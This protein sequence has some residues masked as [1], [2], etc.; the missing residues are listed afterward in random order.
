MLKHSLNRRDFLRLAGLTAASTAAAACAAP[1]TPAPAA[2]AA[3]EGAAQEAEPTAAP[4]AAAATEIRVTHWWGDA[5]NEPIAAFQAANPGVTVKNEAAPWDGYHEKLPTMVAAGNSPDVAFM[6]AGMFM[7][8]LPQGVAKDVTE[9]LKSDPDVKADKWAIDPAIDTGYDNKAF[10]I[11]QWHPDS[12]NIVVNKDLFDAA[13]IKVPELGSDLFMKWTW[14]DFLEAAQALTKKTADGKYEQWGIGGVGRGV[15]SPHRDMVWSNAAEFYDDPTHWAPTKALFTEPAFVEAWQWIVDLDL[16]HGVATKPE[17]ESAMGSEGP[18][19][20]GK[21][22][23]TWMWNLYGTMSKAPFAWTVIAPPFQKLRPNK[24]GGNSW[25]MS[26]VTKNEQAAWS[27]MKW[28]A[29]TAEGSTAFAKVGTLPAY[30]PAALLPTA[31]SEGQRTLWQLIIERQKAAVADKIARP[32]SL[33]RHGNEIT[34]I[35]NAENDLIYNGDQT[36]MEG[37]TK[38]KEKAEAVLQAG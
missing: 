31:E 22:G 37:L 1:V 13:G 14:N 33:G 20:S 23:M 17:D 29:M 11:P 38:A 12:A 21:V 5:F 34:N 7:V 35:L 16:K 32:F 3:G 2:P 36:V 10:G 19:L 27:F 9:I 8:M 15:W 6:D 28:A 24:Y 4:A 26:S 30:D 18:Y 25:T